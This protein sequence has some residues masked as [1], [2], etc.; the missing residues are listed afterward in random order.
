MEKMIFYCRTLMLREA[1]YQ[2]ERKMESREIAEVLKQVSS[3]LIEYK[4]N[5][6]MID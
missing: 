6:G 5:A 4:E 3:K 1:D 2:D